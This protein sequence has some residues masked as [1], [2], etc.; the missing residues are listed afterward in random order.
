MF[1]H[2]ISYEVRRSHAGTALGMGWTVLQPLL[3]LGCYFF[4]FAV[5]RVP[6]NAP[7][8]TLG[9]VAV[10]L[11][12]IVPW[13][14]FMRC[15]SNGLG[16][17]PNHAQLVRQINFPIGVLPFVTV[18]I[19]TIDFLVGIAMLLVVVVAQGWLG[20][21]TLL[22]IPA[23]IVQAAFLTGLTAML[24]PL[25]VMLRDA[26]NLLPVIVRLGLF[27]SPVL[28]IPGTIPGR[29]QWVMYVNPMTY[30]IGLVRFGTFGTTEVPIRA[31]AHGTEYAPLNLLPPAPTFAIALACA[32]ATA[33]G[34]Y[35]CWGYARRVAVD[36]L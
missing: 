10:I 29:F 27:L 6:T 34:G 26:R 15:F 20:W 2:L 12:G 3:L 17:L 9:K 1:A 18:G 25:G 14:F 36:Y 31:T 35:L 13:L 33:I 28:Y 7:E 5:L 32:L 22:L 19:F 23:T 21:G 24:A 8:G 4:L 16:A 30:F 11:S